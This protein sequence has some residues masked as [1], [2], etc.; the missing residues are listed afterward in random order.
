[1]SNFN[2]Y[3]GTPISLSTASDWTKITVMNFRAN[4]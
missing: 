1:M 4:Y 2:G 3:E